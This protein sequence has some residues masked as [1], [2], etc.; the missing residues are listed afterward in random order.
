MATRIAISTGRCVADVVVD[1]TLVGKFYAVLDL[2]DEFLDAIAGVPVALHFVCI[3]FT[4]DGVD[5]AVSVKNI[6]KNLA[7]ALVWIA[8]ACFF[9]FVSIFA[10]Y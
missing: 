1:A 10:W 7:E 2:R 4:I 3:N 5:L 8:A 6:V 9:E